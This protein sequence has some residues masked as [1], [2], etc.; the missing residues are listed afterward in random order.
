M[1]QQRRRDNN[2]QR[3]EEKLERK[4]ENKLDMELEMEREVEKKNDKNFSVFI[5][6]E[7]GHSM[8][9][10]CY[11]ESETVG[12]IKLKIVHKMAMED[13]WTADRALDI[14]VFYPYCRLARDDNAT[15]AE[16]GVSNREK[17]YFRIKKGVIVY[18]P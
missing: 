17:I 3:K 1:C 9:Q 14:E 2:K 18:A 12:E 16:L 6:N 11:V 10:L 8:E 7:Y 5:E 13:I 4:M 15:L